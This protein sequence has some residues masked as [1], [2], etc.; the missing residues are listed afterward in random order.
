MQK[1]SKIRI[2]KTDIILS[3]GSACRTAHHLRKNHLRSLSS[4]LDWMVSGDLDIIY[5]LFCND[6]KDFFLNYEVVKHSQKSNKVDEPIHVKDTK[7]NILSI[8][9]FFTNEDLKIQSKR[10]NEQS[11]YRWNKIKQKLF[12]AKNITFIHCGQ[13]EL[14]KMKKFLIK[15]SLLLKINRG[16]GIIKSIIL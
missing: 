7:Y 4:P 3:L 13:F 16:G 14:E 1:I 12:L 2:I 9:H 6:F 11:I 5:D 15:I 10:V 8:H